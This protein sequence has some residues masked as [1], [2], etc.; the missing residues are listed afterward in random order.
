MTAVVAVLGLV[1]VAVSV[2]LLSD[3]GPSGREASREGRPPGTTA[4]APVEPVQGGEVIDV[5]TM[6]PDMTTVFDPAGAAEF[7]ELQ[8]VSMLYDGLTEFDPGEVEDPRPYPAVAERWE[9]SPDGLTWTFLI[10]AGLA[11]SDGTPV[12]PS[13]FV[14]AW[15][16][17]T[18]PATS[19]RLVYLFAPVAGALAKMA[20]DASTLSGVV[21]DDAAMTLRVTLEYAVGD[22]DAVVSHPVFSPL[23][24]ALDRAPDLEA[25]GRSYIDPENA[26]VVG[27]GPFVPDGA[28]GLDAMSLIPNPEWD[29]TRYDQRLHLQARPYLDRVTFWSRPSAA[30]AAQA[31]SSGL[32][33]VNRS[34]TADG[35]P[36]APPDGT[37]STVGRGLLRTHFLAFQWDDRVVGRKVNAPLRAAIM[38]AIDR[39]RIAT[40][41]YRGAVS[42]ATAFTPPAMPGGGEDPCEGACTYDPDAARRALER[43]NTFGGRDVDPLRV[44]HDDSLDDVRVGAIIVENLEAIGLEV[45]NVTLGAEEYELAMDEGE[46]QLCWRTWSAHVPSYDNLL[47]Q[48]VG[49]DYWTRGN[50]SRFTSPAV[51]TQFDQARGLLDAADRHAAYREAESLALEEGAVVPVL[52][53][54]GG[55]VYGASVA[56]LPQQATGIVAWERAGLRR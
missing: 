43:W 24:E 14:R 11:F 12:L 9:V 19:G 13:S 17:A 55:Y 37:A 40:E 31:F 30:S 49:D 3:S 1:G 36:L 21:A 20:G 4:T 34:V 25:W 33:Q 35:G 38:L 5:G 27:N 8:L 42:P 47:G 28:P 6:T 45:E 56:S 23:P 41:V 44:V 29:G 2:A 18:S 26:L 52:W 15:E 53:E 50:Y 46:C 54:G 51:A 10:R 48:V 39:E 16:R 32:A 22:F 7:R